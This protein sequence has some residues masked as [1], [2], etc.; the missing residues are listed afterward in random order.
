[1][2]RRSYIKNPGATLSSLLENISA[3]YSADLVCPIKLRLATAARSRET[4]GGTT[5]LIVIDENDKKYFIKTRNLTSNE[6]IG[7]LQQEYISAQEI[8]NTNTIKTPTPLAY[9]NTADNRKSFAIYEYM[10]VGYKPNQREL[11][12]Q[13]AKLHRQSSPCSK[14]GFHIDNSLLSTPQ[15]NQPWENSWGTFWDSNR[16][17]PM[18]QLTHNCCGLSSLDVYILRSRTRFLLSSHQPSSSLLH[19]DLSGTNVGYGKVENS[20][21]GEVTTRPVIFDP[22]TYYGDREVDLAISE[23]FGGFTSE[24]Y[25]GYNEEWPIPQDYDQRKVVYQLYH[26]CVN[27]FCF[28]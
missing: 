27:D 4:R 25:R 3:A 15:C 2:K 28:R 23:L 19:G 26:M 9:G 8:A 1:M 14:F 20:K 17:Y 10:N 5:S 11:G 6:N 21:T 13:L 18:L 16:L 7:L 24:F 12:H 22:S